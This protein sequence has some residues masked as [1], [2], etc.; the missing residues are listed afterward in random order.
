MDVRTYIAD[1]V[2]EALQMVRDDLGPQ[3]IVLRTQEVRAGGLWG[4]LGGRRCMQ[5]TA[6]TDL[7]LQGPL[8]HSTPELDRGIDLCQPLTRTRR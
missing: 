4:I 2:H 7:T 3:A 8:L 6:S 1:S 5:I